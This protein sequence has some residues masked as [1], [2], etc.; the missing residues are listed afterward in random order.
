MRRGREEVRDKEASRLDESLIAYDEV[1]DALN[2]DS[3]A[4]G[5]GISLL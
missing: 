5:L 3:D 1:D 2:V 4:D